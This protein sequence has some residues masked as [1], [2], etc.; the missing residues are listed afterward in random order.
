M[1][2]R[3]VQSKISEIFISLAET[4][5]DV[6]ISRQVLTE[7]KE[8]N[9]YQIFS[10]LDSNKK[11]YIEGLDIINYLQ[12]KNIFLTEIETKLLI[13]YYDQDLDTNLNFN[14]FIE[15][16]ESK[17][18]PK[19]EVKE[20]GGPLCF[21]VD[22]ALTKLLEKE[23]I[24]ARNIIK[25]LED[26]RGFSEFE[27]HNIFHFVKNNNNNC[28]VPQNII[29]FLNKN[30]ASFIDQDIDL[31]FKRIDF[32]KDNVIDLCE[33]HIFFGFPNC[34][35]N[36][37]FEKCDN[38]GIECCQI[39]RINGPCYVHKYINK[40]D[41]NYMQKRVYRT[42]YTEFQ[43]K[44]ND[45]K[46]IN[47]KEIPSIENNELNNGIQKV[48][49]NLTLKLSPKR[50]YE[51]CLNSNNYKNDNNNNTT[52][53]NIGN[54]NIN[55]NYTNNN[56]KDDNEINKS[57]HNINENINCNQNTL[58]QN[59]IANNNNNLINEYKENLN[60]NIQKYYNYL[61]NNNYEN[62]NIISSENRINTNTNLINSYENYKNIQNE[63]LNKNRNKNRNEYEESQF[64]NYLNE[65]MLQESNIERLK[66]QLSLRTDFNWEATF[67]IF[68]LEGRGY[69]S[70]EDLIIG[71]NKLGIY[72]KDLDMSLLL[73][74]YDLQKEGI[75][76]YPDFYELIVPFSK[77][78]RK[79]VDKRQ[80]KNEN[81]VVNPNEFNED[82]L[83][84][85]RNL[86]VTIFK[87]EFI[88]NKIKENFTSLKMKFSDIF[89]L[90]DPLGTG[91]IEEN[92]L[93]IFLQKND[94][95]SI[96]DDC[97][98]LFLRL[99]KLRNGKIEFQ[100]MCDEIEAIYE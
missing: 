47:N 57:N 86:F 98:L 13:L 16:I 44:N 63:N 5:R 30:Y 32:N 36:C 100:E 85:I 20:V 62:K 95:F 35:Y 4:E 41:E 56:F 68:E 83:N 91:Y 7:Y 45:N 27:I 59:F 67:R 49:Q 52:N 93:A 23:I 92:E 96:D 26:L 31:I 6:E 9:P 11:N 2:S 54:N 97:D 22:Y 46:E 24:H 60:N 48:S 10:F 58:E 94:I 75:I 29:N 64:I 70:K 28:M 43:N 14:E 37:P 74:R 40:K 51:V 87:G 50:E 18:S 3:E 1:L 99:N 17:I 71:F 42:Y 19:K 76:S 34:G 82:T 61:Y 77:Y 33:F 15:L 84:C 88:L 65:A 80:N 55:N 66:I 73:K 53:I 39:C 8:Y 25:L 12:S 79:M 89:H 21:S 81:L 90:L 72:P 78:H 38:C 69:L